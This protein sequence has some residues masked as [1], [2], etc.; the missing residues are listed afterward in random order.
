[1]TTPRTVNLDLIFPESDP[2]ADWLAEQ[3]EAVADD[4]AAWV[5]RP[6]GRGGRAG[7][8]G[9]GDGRES[10]VGERGD[11]DGTRTALPL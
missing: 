2:L 5:S 7:G 3:A 10:V 1:M 11:G 6:A 8:E 4:W 9:G